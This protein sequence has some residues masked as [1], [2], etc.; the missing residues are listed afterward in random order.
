MIRGQ[1]N[2]A[3]S[4]NEEDATKKEEKLINF[5]FL[6]IKIFVSGKYCI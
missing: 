5:V 4:D 3:K 1:L 6:V 2:D